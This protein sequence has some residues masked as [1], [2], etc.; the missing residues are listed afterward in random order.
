ML[1]ADHWLL[2]L[3][4]QRYSSPIRFGSGFQL[5]CLIAYLLRQPFGSVFASSCC[6][7]RGPRGPVSICIVV[8]CSVRVCIFVVVCISVNIS[9]VTPF[10]ASSSL[11]RSHQPHHRTRGGTSSPSLVPSCSPLPCYAVCT[12]PSQIS[13]SGRPER[14]RLHHWCICWITGA[15]AC[16]I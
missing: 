1:I 12:R 3:R 10:P 4:T 11:E 2:G 5:D 7:V 9:R 8:W 6:I 16:Q 14:S 15:S 13:H